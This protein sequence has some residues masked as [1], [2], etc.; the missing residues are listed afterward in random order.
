MADT[1]AAPAADKLSP[2]FQPLRSTQGADLFASDV[3]DIAYGLETI[4][5]MLEQDA[6]S[7]GNHGEAPL[8]GEYQAGV[9]LRMGATCAKLL[10][11]MAQ[12]Q[13]DAAEGR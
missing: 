9:M 10:G 7:A 13:L 5:E 12:T 8:L 6:I 3:R 2:L 4:I 11:R 1:T